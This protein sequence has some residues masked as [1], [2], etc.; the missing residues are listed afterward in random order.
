MVYYFHF[1]DPTDTRREAIITKV[2]SRVAP[3]FFTLRSS[4]RQQ[5]AKEGFEESPL[6]MF[7]YV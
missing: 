5:R 7:N 4:L 2:Q 1:D 6:Q 3:R